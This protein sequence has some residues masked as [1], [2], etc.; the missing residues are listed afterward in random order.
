MFEG[1]GKS[2]ISSLL[3]TQKHKNNGSIYYIDTEGGAS[4]ACSYFAIDY[5]AFF[6]TWL[7][8]EKG[9]DVKNT[10][11]HKPIFSK[12]Y[13]EYIEFLKIKKDFK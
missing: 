10:D 4:D 6:H 7:E 2:L 12:Y 3:N 8:N 13:N 1:Y 9:I 5:D 11:L